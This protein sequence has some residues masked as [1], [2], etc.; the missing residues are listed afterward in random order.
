MGFGPKWVSWIKQCVITAYF[1][2]LVNGSPASFFNSSRGLRQGDPLSPYL[3]VLGMEVFS[4]LMEKS[5]SEG[6]LQGHKFVNRSGDELQLNHLLLADDTLVF[7]KDSIDQ[8]AYLSWILLWFEA[9]SRL[10]INLDKSS[11]MPVGNVENLV[12]F[13]NELG[14][15][16]GNLPTTYLGLPLGMHC[17]FVSIWD[18][19]E[20]W[21]RR[22]LASWKRQHISKGG[23][24]TLIKSTLSNLLIYT[25]SL[26]RLPKGVKARL[27]K[28]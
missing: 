20:E 28:I 22:K 11:I 15:G 23:R 18:G 10:N 12:L 24:L 27:E 9:I 19:V 3:F 2:V 6:F 26:F 16:T 1:S 21:F 5:A 17:N 25:M 7:C 4:I 8:L 14:C 13:A